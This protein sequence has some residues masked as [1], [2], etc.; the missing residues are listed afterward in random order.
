MVS[1][2]LRIALPVPVHGLFDY[3]P[4]P[5]V[6][7][8]DCEPGMRVEVPFGPSR[9]IGVLVERVND[10]PV[11]PERLR[12]ACRLLD[13]APLLDD[14]HR[15]FLAW[16]AA[17]YHH[18]IGEVFASALPLRLRKRAEPLPLRAPGYA[19][20]VGPAEALAQVARAPR[21][22][23]LI[24]RLAAA[25]GR[26]QL[27]AE[28][29]VQ[30]GDAGAVIRR[31]LA[32]GLIVECELGEVDAETPVPGSP[33]PVLHAEQAAAVQAVSEALGG[34]AA[35][36][37]QGVTGSGKTEVYLR[38]AEQVLARGDSVLVLVPEIALTPQLARR[39]AERLGGGV[40]LLHSGLNDSERE[41][42]WQRVRLGRDRV[43]LGTR[44]TVL[45]PID[46]LGLVIVDEEHDTS[47]KQQEGFRYS[48]RDL[49][50][51]RARRAGCPV[52]LGS[53][54]PS[55][56]SLRN[57][58]LGRYRRLWL[59]QR[60]GGAQPPE[61]RLLDIRD[62]PLRSGLSDPLLREIGQTLAAGEQ[63]MVFLNRR[64]YAPVLACH[65]C[66]WVSDCPRCDARQTV[67]RGHGLLWCHHCGSQRRV[68][69]QCP[70][71]GSP[72]LRPLG[73]GTE[74]IEQ[75]LAAEFPD[76]PL[77][78][79][80]R[81]ATARKGSLDRLL[82][83]V[84]AAGAA[85]LVG[86]Q[87]LAKGHHFPDVTLVGVVDADGGLFSADFRAPE[88]MA[89][90]LVQVAGRAGRGE[91]P[92]RVLIQTRYPEHPLLQVL[93]R[94]GYEGFARAALRER[95]EAGWPPFSHQALLR[96]EATQA[97]RP[98]A[99][100]QGLADALAGELPEGVE[101]WGP[102]P[103]PM[104]RRQGRYRAHLLVQASRREALHPLLDR[105]LS[106]ARALP[107]ARRVRWSLD[108]DPVDGL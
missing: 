63:V 75:L 59:R 10:S 56:E 15:D 66:G 89:Q 13:S 48:A 22:R 27:R 36:L 106:I 96:A 31:L 3:L 43:V 51:I 34:F 28:L 7:A 24:E 85:L 33:L 84:H 35:F 101:L 1:P 46:R 45:Y 8:E 88:R 11:P 92:G 82:A 98:Q 25:P 52:V 16:V 80:D 108:V 65:A 19:L 69:A 104:Q 39:F 12:P 30:G 4:P 70:A 5:G 99:F 74:R 91:K 71:C 42:A 86:T 2:L 77:I 103:A 17:Y 83:Q 14:V 40:A 90:L 26:R 94:E 67:H 32:K 105:L 57:V 58:E 18:G 81:D 54:T 79:I 41:L 73:Q 37:L 107:E 21:Q 62:Q 29:R 55:F 87:M 50:V 23:E 68:P 93:V 53:A 49:A 9:R 64:G 38:L 97:E 44:S 47:F 72:E 100:L 76:V 60:A 102:V 20:A 95:A 6:M 61:V 78:R